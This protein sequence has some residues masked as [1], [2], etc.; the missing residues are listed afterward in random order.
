MSDDVLKIIPAQ[1]G[2]RPSRTSA[3][4]AV[5]LLQELLR[6]CP[7][8]RDRSERSRRQDHS[9]F[10]DPYFEGR[11]A[12]RKPIVRNGDAQSPNLVLIGKR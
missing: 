8:G 7:A 9:E 11:S 2:H 12:A 4:E 3:D 6:A 1:V 10:G 5:T